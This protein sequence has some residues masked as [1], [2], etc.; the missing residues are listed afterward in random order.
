MDLQDRVAIVTGGAGG[1]GRGIARELAARGADVAVADIDQN[2]ARA[3]AGELSVS[4]R[5]SI[6]LE[7]DVASPASTDR[8]VEAALAEFGKVD[9]LVNSAGVGG[10]PGWEG[11]S[12]GAIE[13]WDAAYSVNAL[14]IVHA[15]DSVRAHLMGRRSGKVVTIAAAAGRRGDGPLRAYI[16]ASKAAAVN[17]SQSFAFWLAPFNINVNCVCPGLVWTPLWEKVGRERFD[18]LVRETTPLGR[19]Q[20]PED[21]GK[22]AAFLCSER[23]RNI[24]G[25][26]INLSGGWQMN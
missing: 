2:A 16:S 5:R 9:I 21:V 19:E 18:A 11:R 4:G 17:V 25:Q 6:A 22:L 12:A 10:A 15:T 23:A 7:A 8:M 26:T 3:V 1:I 20:T 14:G 24:T 13:D